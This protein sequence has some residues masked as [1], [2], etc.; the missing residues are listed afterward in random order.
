[1]M[2]QQAQAFIK[3]HGIDYIMAQFVDIHG[4]ANAKSVPADHLE[5]ILTDGAGFVGFAVW[6]MGQG[7]HEHDFMAIGDLSTLSLVPWQPGYARM[8]KVS[9]Q[10][11]HEALEGLAASKFFAAQLGRAF[12]D[13]FIEVKRMEWVDCARHVSDWKVDRY[14]SFY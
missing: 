6:G 13:K 7:P 2:L 8:L 10:T 9:P 3:E 11:L 5:D 1:M 14:L 4:V 12:I